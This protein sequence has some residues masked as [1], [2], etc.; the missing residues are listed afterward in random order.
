RMF[1]TTDPAC[2][3]STYDLSAAP[4][5]PTALGHAQR[6]DRGLL[7]CGI[8][9]RPRNDRI[10]SRGSHQSLSQ[11]NLPGAAV[12]RC[13]NGSQIYSMTSSARASSVSGTERPIAFAVL[14]L[15]TSSYLV[16]A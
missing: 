12:S 6:K 15:I 11:Q 14:R 1:D 7:H 3:P 13:N 16:G 5:L 4:Q 2:I 10:T 9:V 8:S